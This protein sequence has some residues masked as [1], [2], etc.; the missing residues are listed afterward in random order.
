M[1]QRSSH[2]LRRIYKLLVKRRFGVVLG[3]SALVL[4]VIFHGS[5]ARFL[6]IT[7]V[8]ASA[9]Q[10]QTGYYVGNGASK[11]ISGLGFTPEVV[12]LKADSADGVGAVMKTIAMPQNNVTYLGTA[13]ADDTTGAI[14]LTEGG[15]IVTGTLSNTTNNRYT[16]VAFSGSDCSVSG[17]LCVGSYTGD[18]VATKLVQSGF[19]PDLALIKQSTAVSANWRSSSMPDNYAQFFL[20]NAQDTAGTYFTTLNAT[21]F[22][23]GSTNNVGGG[24]YYFVVFK[25]VTG[26]IDVGTYIGDTSDNR[27]ITG[28]G[29]QPDWVFTKNA[30]TAVSAVYNLNESY[31]DYSSYF[32]NTPNLVNAV[33]AL[34]ADGFQ[35][36]TSNTANESTNTHYYAAFGGAVDHTAQGTFTA[37]S[38]TYVGDGNARV[39]SNLGFKPDLVIVKASSTQQAVFSTSIMG[40][41]STAYLGSATANFADGIT[42]LSPNGFTIGSHATVNTAG[43]E[44][45]WTAYGNA[46][47]PE[48]NTGSQ[49]F[50]IGAY[51]GNTLDTRSVTRIPFQPNLIVIKQGGTGVGVWRS[52][53]HTGDVTSYFNATADGANHIQAL[54]TTG[55]Q[56]GTDANV[57][58]AG[59]LYWYFG[60]AEGTH[61]EVGSYSGTG[62]TQNIGTSFEPDLVWVKETGAEQ[63]VM[64]T[65]STTGVT[66]FPFID[67]ALLTDA[68]TGLYSNGF[69]V[70]T[71]VAVNSVGVNNYRYAVWKDT[72]TVGTSTY[73]MQ[74]GYYVGSGES[75]EISGLGFTPDMVIIKANTITGTGALWKTTAMPQNN[76]AFLGTASADN[77]TGLIVFTDDGFRVTGAGTNNVNVRFTWVAYSGS[78]CSSGGVLCVGRYTGDGSATKAITS[79]FQPDLVWVKQST[80]VVPTWRSS[81]MPLNYAQYFSATVQDTTGTFFTSLDASGFTV[82]ATHNASAGVY[83]YATFKESAGA[84]DVGTY[85]GNGTVDRSIAGVGFRP[86]FMFI[87][88]AGAT[89]GAVYSLNESHGDSSSYFSD[90]ANL[91][92]A[93][94]A[95]ETDGFQVGTHATVH[96]NGVTYYYA[97]FGDAEAYA[98]SGTYVIN[99]GSYVGTG[100]ATIISDVGFRPDLVIIKGNTTQSGVFRTRMMGGDSTAYLDAATANFAGGITALRSDSFTLGT[101]ATVNTP[102]VTYHWT[103]YGNAW[104]PSRGT[105]SRDFVI[106]AYYGNGIDSRNITR[107]PFQPDFVSIKR[108]GASGGVWRSSAHG[109]DI[110]SYFTAT[111]DAANLVQSLRSDGFQ[112]G[113]LA[114][115]NTV[116]NMYW[117][118]GFATSS[119]F[120]VGTYSGTGSSQDITVGFQPDHIWVKSTT[121]T[122]GVLRPGSIVGDG[123]L[124]FTNTALI[125]NAITG[126]VEKGFSLGS[127]SETNT[128]GI[129]N[130]RYVAWKKSVLHQT[131]YHW[132]LD[133]GTEANASSAT[134]GVEDT[135]LTGAAEGRPYR[136]RVGISNETT[137]TASSSVFRLEYGEKVTTCSAVATWTRVT[138]NNSAWS[139]YDSPNLTEGAHTTNVDN[140]DGGVTDESSVFLTPNGAVRDTTDET[141]ALTLE[142]DEFLEL[143]YAI[144]PTQYATD[145]TQYCFRISAQGEALSEYPEYPEATFEVHMT[146]TS[147]GSQV[148]EVTIPSTNVYL[149]G[150]FVLSDEGSGDSHVVTDI[151]ITETGTVDA[152]NN[153]KNIKLFYEYDTSAPYDCVSESYDGTEVQFGVTDIDGFSN[154]DG[155]ASFAGSLSASSTQAICVYPVMD[156]IGGALSGETIELQITSANEI[157]LGGGEVLRMTV[158]LML[159][160]TT[161]LSAPLLTQTHYHWRLDDG[162]EATAGSA[163]GGTEDTVLVNLPKTTPHRIRLQVSNEGLATSSATTFRLEYAERGESCSATASGWT[164]VA[165]ADGAWDMYNSTNLTEGTDTT[166]I[167]VASGGVTDENSV[168][169]T[170]NGAV[171]DTTSETGALTLAP[172]EFV[173]F[174]YSVVALS[175]AVEAESYC[176]RVTESGTPLRV[177]EVYPEVSILADVLVSARGEHVAVLPAGS[178]EKY[179]GGSW[180]VQDFGGSRDVTSITLTEKGTVDA[181]NKLKNIKLFYEYDDS[182]PYTCA[183]ESYEGDEEQYGATDTD[184]FSSANG[185]STFSETVG[186]SSTQA[187]C[188]YAVMDVE[189]SAGNLET[190]MLEIT[191]PANDVTISSGTINPDSPVGPTGSTT[192]EKALLVVEHYHFRNDDGNES[193]ATSKTGGVEDV[194]ITGALPGVPE[195]LRFAI[196]NS[197]STSSTP[198]LFTLQYAERVT[199]CSVANSWVTVGATGAVWS[200]SESLILTNGED[201]TNIGN[202]FGGVTDENNVFLTPNSGVI[203]NSA[204]STALSLAS[205]EFVELEYVLE[206]NE[207]AVAGTTYCFRVVDEGGPFSSYATYA[208]A[209]VRTSQDF[210][211]QRGVSDIA[212]GASTVTITAGTEYV[213]PTA[214]TSAFIRITNAAGMGA[215]PTSGGG[216][217]NASNVTT[218]IQN[219]SNIETSVTFQRTGTTNS[220]RIYWEI[221]EYT[222][223]VGGDNEIRVRAQQTVPY[224]SENT[225]VTTP[226]VQGVVSDSDVVVFITGQ[227]NP[228]TNVTSYQAGLSTAVWN[229][230]SDDA[231]F[232]RGISGSVATVVSYAIVEFTGD[233]WR[234]QRSQHTYGSAGGTETENITTVNDLSRA[235]L[236]AQK[237]TADNYV[238]EFGHQVW[239]LNVGQVAYSIPSTARTPANHTSVAW[240]IENTQVTGNPMVVTRSNATQAPGGVEPSSYAIPIGTTI[241]SLSNGS[242][243][244]NMWGLGSD[245]THPRAIMGAGITSTSY[246]QLWISDTGTSRSY[247]TEIVNWPTAVLTVSQNFFRF[248]ADNDALIPTDPWPVGAVDLGE[249]TTVTGLD[250]PPIDG[251]RVRVRMSLAVGGANISQGTK[252]YKL[253][254]GVRET[255]CSAI[256][257]WLDTGDSASTTAVWRGFNATP[258]NGSALSTNP[259]AFGDLLLSISDRAGTFEEANPTAVNPYK[260]YMGDDVEYDWIL[261]ANGVVDFTSY[262][263]RMTE[264]DG[265]ELDEYVYYPTMTIAGFQVE[266]HAWRWY[267]DEASLTPTVALSAT[268]TAPSN[269]SHQEVLKLRVLVEEQAGRDG[270]NTKFKLQWSEFSDFSVVHDVADVDVCDTDSPWCYADGA[271]AEEDVIPDSVLYNYDSCVGGVG[272]GCG[273]HNEYS[274]TPDVVGEVGTTTTDSGG[275]TVILQHTYDDPVFIVEALSGDAQGGAINRPAV[276]IITATT[277]SSFT[278]RIQEP[279]NEADT[280]GVETLSYIVMERGAYTLPDGRRVD[281]NTIDTNHYYGNAV[282]G[283]S[284]D[285]CSFTQ[286]FTS[287]PVVL[288]SLQTNN[289]TGVPD[290]LTASIAL[291]SS[292]DFA[293]S[294]EVPD[295]ETN[296]PTQGETIGWIAIEGGTF[297]NNRIAFEAT[298]T[299]PSITGWV[300]TPWYEQTF[301]QLFTGIPG[302]VANKQTR[303]GAEGGWVRYANIDV[304]SFQSA[305]D[306]RD[307]GERTHTTEVVAYF[308]HSEGGVLY[309]GGDSSFVFGNATQKEFEYTLQHNSARSNMTYFFRLYDVGRDAPVSATSTTNYPSLSTEGATLNFSITGINAGVVT[310]G[311]TTDITSTA[312]ALPFGSLTLGTPKN[313]AQR[314]IVTTN[315]SEGYQILAYEQQDLVSSGGAVIEDVSGSNDSPLPWSTGCLV[316]A[317][318]CYG[319][320]V[321]D[322]TLAGGSSRFLLNDTFAPL[323][324]AL[325][326]VAYSSGPVRDESTDIIYRVKVSSGQ[327]AGLYESRIVY[328]VVPVF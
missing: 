27:S 265:T 181:Q 147:T 253:Q 305:I 44:Y 28:V 191:N 291:V 59:A 158:P 189:A 9:Y 306:E 257:N 271:G 314:L 319:Y 303:N 269:I 211:I 98:A 126:L 29:F 32:T 129:N 202:M 51:Y 297:S 168:F 222:G 8:E 145:M 120:A 208:E 140:V 96:T 11:E 224:G 218:S 86:D 207:D 111:N 285:T 301:T 245:T 83:Y 235:F 206:P 295:S 16:W 30:N 186:I 240:I 23:V 201:T 270:S 150:A 309:R 183:S 197:G 110:S 57:N 123:A 50:V 203:E 36:G 68:I 304:D 243:F 296:E 149:G 311:V 328:I 212:N 127:A 228:A 45:V 216:A 229:S 54:E 116:A 282:S 177:Y 6:G 157:V 247:R 94:Q 204:Q 1:I 133:D 178:T 260:I 13:T 139:M 199:T 205:D 287:A 77:T 223:P 279:D 39:I 262:C 40:G 290:F 281:V 137:I 250:V 114:N 85:T 48:T 232:T 134:G 286:T 67:T 103:A 31:G 278:V 163:T 142:G 18:G 217:Q 81:V 246:Y 234:I 37:V 151:T 76:T 164:N 317:Q 196:N 288:T 124:P 61:F 14:Q 7:Q 323:T 280:H 284:D 15:F 128:S 95:L 148:A 292:D 255:A 322:N 198:S 79:G 19:E 170:P 66:S 251:D 321:G 131:H 26:L 12:I 214:S 293:C 119:T 154:T 117:Y 132:R 185:T 91:V 87:K 78:E 56:I 141:G 64:R 209:S 258:L 24:I 174:E 252:Q 84:V 41:D 266:Q 169:L 315:A 192:I 143:E 75:Q 267:D 190:I 194:P 210:Y 238:A 63:G 101:N 237:R 125:A 121:A 236:H 166:N 239:L 308:A 160:S 227:Q 268:N 172:D 326:E 107:L 130:Y 289:N 313:A 109:G 73:K 105:G 261:E 60:F 195:R 135:P 46:W 318:S 138:S 193:L 122:Q 17:Q 53:A 2:N 155:T 92:D 277:T 273:T 226:T 152:Q 173:E 144:T 176:F 153:L 298:T 33:Q 221:I 38:G 231:T 294:M 324:G 312:T 21:G 256:S 58:T 156:V 233:N 274:Y 242:I 69:S 90:T 5:I 213:A 310:E 82:G 43:V 113:T 179:L 34:E 187:L 89:V 104:D 254:Y 62:V 3:I 171:R 325:E 93:I 215:G 74:T 106:G 244:M 70:G 97:A 108:S 175:G 22:T 25:E 307:D 47:N 88:N 162:T 275:T 115:V 118:F 241:S 80:E 182:S 55:F 259:P 283:A 249:N 320:H 42:T 161:V 102:G 180:V 316:S 272:D 219:P 20:A 220:T 200:P 299:L 99:S 65:A 4:I 225:T 159:D 248:Y 146:A 112:V 263:F 167:S 49:D 10:M 302:I 72:T 300:D 165:D 100:N 184:G 327:S 264:T 136:L 276:A 35:V 188:L 71:N 230:G 52:S